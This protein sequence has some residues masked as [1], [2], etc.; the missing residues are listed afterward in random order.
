MNNPIGWCDETWNPFV[1]CSKCSLGCQNCYAERFA[2][3]GRLQRFERYK[4]V[5]TDGR[6]NGRVVLHEKTMEK[7]LHWREPRKIFVNDM[8][9]TFHESV[10]FENIAKVFDVMC[11]WRWP[12]KKAQK[13]GDE[14]LL[15][16]PGHT[17]FILTKRPERI[18]LFLN[19]YNENCRGDA[20]FGITMDVLG[21][22]PKHIFIGCTICKEK[23]ADEKTPLLLQ[24]PAAVRFLSI[25]PMLE[26]IDLN[27]WL[28]P[29]F[30]H[31]TGLY[32][33]TAEP[34][35]K[36]NWV[37]VGAES[38]S[39]ARH[40]WLG[41]IEL[42]VDQCTTAGVPVWVKQVHLPADNKKG[43]RLSKDMSEWPEKL[44]RR[45]FPQ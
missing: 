41:W 29:Q 22:I 36:P 2:A 9:D 43:F 44:R 19:W 24:I 28:L 17:Y 30:R 40:C 5:I 15:V 37:I 42:I 11:S 21:K 12:N 8:S 26:G 1:G 14:S 4:Q 25:E 39:K 33:G 20:P 31:I 23:E 18:P 7:P 13:T 3:S 32:T 10:P 38:G 34:H 45:E 16:A 6:W 35:I 27:K